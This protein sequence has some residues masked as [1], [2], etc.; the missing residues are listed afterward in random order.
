MKRL[1]KLFI[2]LSIF[3]LFFLSL[4]FFLILSNKS[5]SLHFIDVGEGEAILIETPSKK[6]L[7]DT[8]NLITGVKVLK[9]LQ[10]RG[11]HFLDYLII[12]HPHPDHMG[13]VFVLF[14]FI[15]I[16]NLYDNGQDL[17][18]ISKSQDIY[19]WYEKLIRGKNYRRLK[20]GDVLSLGKAELRIIWPPQKFIFSDFNSNSLVIMVKYKKFKCLLTADINKKVEK[21]LLREKVNLS[22]S[23]LKISHHGARDATSLEFLKAVSPKEAII[24]IDKDNIRGYPQKE[25]LKR[26][27]LRGI[28]V[29][30][31]YR[32]GDIVIRV[33]NK[34]NYVINVHRKEGY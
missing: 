22:A 16:K 30:R 27:K 7:V 12:T 17:S 23:V 6:A 8:G 33:K 11:I 4:S 28:K 2:F 34:G 20:E 21:E 9:Y 14:P 26:L 19:R 18:N 13:G 15:E 1:K 25:V 32:Q 24:S 31:T 29:Y 10:G 3:S 5:I